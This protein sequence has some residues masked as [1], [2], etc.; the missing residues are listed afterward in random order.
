MKDILSS[1]E[2]EYGFVA[3]DRSGAAVDVGTI[4]ELFTKTLEAQQPWLPA[5]DGGCFLGNGARLYWDAGA[6][7]E[8]AAP[9]C[10]GHPKHLVAHVR[11]G[12]AIML[13]VA[14][15]VER[16]RR[17][18]QVR[19]WRGNVEYLTGLSWGCHENYLTQQTSRALAPD[20][21][22]HLVS[23]VIYGGAG[24]WSTRDHTRFSL[25]PRLELFDFVESADTMHARG[26]INTRDEPHA[27]AH[28]RLHL[29]CRDSVTSQLADLLS[30]GMTRLIVA[31]ADMNLHP[32]RGLRLEDEVAALHTVCADTSCRARLRT[33]LGAITAIEIQ[34]GYLEQI[35]AQRHRLPTWSGEIARMCAAVLDD[36]ADDPRLLC[37]KLDWPTKLAIFEQSPSRDPQELLMQDV[38]LS[39]LEQTL[40]TELNARTGSDVVSAAD[41]E[42]AVAEAPAMT[43]ARVRGEVVKRLSGRR[44]AY[45]NWSEM[46]TRDQRLCLDE[47]FESRERWRAV[48]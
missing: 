39:D 6:H 2:T 35:D 40:L 26:L 31:L 28:R 23:R 7:P 21:L 5:A 22:P 43:R 30:I 4:V 48:G 41:I 42:A 34:R 14:R 47:P 12:H 46:R 44:D 15:Q 10:A 37:G 19:V 3:L 17:I 36:M 9:E 29:I 33:E 11:A 8:Y 16:H 32:A 25:S 38:L 1:L 13:R 20:L 18:A 45:C 24:G 27:K